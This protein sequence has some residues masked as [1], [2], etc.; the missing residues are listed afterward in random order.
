MPPCGWRHYTQARSCIS[1]VCPPSRVRLGT[2]GPRGEEKKHLAVLHQRATVK[3]RSNWARQELQKAFEHAQR[4]TVSPDLGS[5]VMFLAS[6]PT[7]P[8]QDR[9]C[10]RDTGATRA[11][12]YTVWVMGYGSGFRVQPFNGHPGPRAVLLT[13][14]TPSKAGAGRGQQR[15]F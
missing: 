12:P 1:R 13:A 14:P 3:C 15:R 4:R 10:E 11:A 8:S 9:R 7:T 5:T 2:N 6:F